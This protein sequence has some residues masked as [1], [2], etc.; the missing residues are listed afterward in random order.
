[1]PTF[2][3][4]VLVKPLAWVRLDILA[5]HWRSHPPFF[6]AHRPSYGRVSQDKTASSL[7][8]PAS[9]TLM[10]RAP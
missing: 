2:R 4:E 5:A 1:M 9:Q 3:T 8:P 10:P 6:L 7:H